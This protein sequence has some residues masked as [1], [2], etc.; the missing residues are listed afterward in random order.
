MQIRQHSRMTLPIGPL[1]VKLNL[2]SA[3]P[4]RDE[5]TETDQKITYYRQRKKGSGLGQSMFKFI[6]KKQTE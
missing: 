5:L 2:E 4:K 6:M 1:P 3:S